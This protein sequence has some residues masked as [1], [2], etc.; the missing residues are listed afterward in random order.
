[1]HTLHDALAAYTP[2]APDEQSFKAAMVALLAGEPRALWRDAFSPGHFTGSAL[3]CSRG[4][5]KVLLMRHQHLHRWMQFGGHA[6]GEPD[7][8]RVALR[9]ASEESG[10]A[11]RAFT[12]RPGILDVDIHPI[13]ANP[14]KGEPAHRH[15]D[16]RYLLDLDDGLPLPPNPEGLALRW[17]SL[18]EAA[19]LTAGETG[20]VRMLEKLKG[21]LP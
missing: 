9:E 6:D 21:G 18:D 8:A 5:G 11:E 12:P 15:F 3:V 2:S 14:R 17:L 16:V 4:R 20:L 7:L 19:A 13:P 1:M 10:F